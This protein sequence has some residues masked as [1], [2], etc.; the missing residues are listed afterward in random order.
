MQTSE[1]GETNVI[2]ECISQNVVVARQLSEG[3]S[4]L[5]W[6]RIWWRRIFSRPSHDGFERIGLKTR[7]LLSERSEHVERRNSE[8]SGW[9]WVYWGGGLDFGHFCSGIARFKDGQEGRK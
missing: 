3:Q 9:V 8:V 6:R 4:F 5:F 7:F 1:A 2:N